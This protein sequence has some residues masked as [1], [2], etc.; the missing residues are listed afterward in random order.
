MLHQESGNQNVNNFFAGKIYL[1]YK[2]NLYFL[3]KL[4]F[5]KKS[6]DQIEY[7]EII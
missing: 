7:C 6:A 1:L 5:W 2:V 4:H 3:Q